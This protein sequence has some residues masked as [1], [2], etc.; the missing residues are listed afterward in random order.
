MLAVS[1]EKE[2]DYSRW[3]EDGDSAEEVVP[4]SEITEYDIS[5]MSFNIKNAN[6]DKGT[7]NSWESRRAGV[8]AMIKDKKPLVVGFQECFHSQ[9][10]YVLQQCT[11]YEGYGV[12]RDN[13]SATSGG[14]E[15]VSIIW[16]RNYLELVKCGTYWLS[17]TPDKV[18]YGW[19]ASFHRITSW[20]ILRKKDTGEQF[21]FMNTHLD[22]Q[23]QEAKEN[24]MALNKQKMDEINIQGL[25]VIYLG[26]FNSDQSASW[27]LEVENYMNNAR[28]TAPLS[29]NFLTS[30][31]Y[32][33]KNQQID[34]IYYSNLK[35][36][37]FETIR[38]KYSGII[39]ISDH[40]PIMAKFDF[41]GK[42]GNE[43]EED[44]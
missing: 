5:A 17:Q 20:V 37:S 15:T 1:C 41:E 38:S 33:K 39:Y 43:N 14:G 23:V 11:E 32:G 6:D 24:G 10:N 36:L 2:Y 31:G 9:R 4:P 29:D 16:N 26:D 34:H 19:G 3:Y 7:S 40:Y 25:P 27:M 18:S 13:G 22:H 44:N 12:A 21:M 30:H 42:G 28:K 8:C 35:P